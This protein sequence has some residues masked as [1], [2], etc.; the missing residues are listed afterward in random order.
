MICGLFI[1]NFDN[2]VRIVTERRI[3]SLH[4]ISR[5]I[6]RSLTQERVVQDALNGMQQSNPRDM[7]FA[8]FY[9]VENTDRDTWP[10]GRDGAMSDGIP[11]PSNMK[12][13]RHGSFAETRVQKR[14]PSIRSES[15]A[16]SGHQDTG[17]IFR[18]VGSYGIDIRSDTDDIP[19]DFLS[20]PDDVDCEVN[21]NHPINPITRLVRQVK[22]Q[23]SPL[24]LPDLAEIPFLASLSNG[25]PFNDSPGAAI[26]LP[27]RSSLEDRLHGVML[28]GLSTR[29]P[30]D[31]EYSNYVQLVKGLLA[32]GLATMKLHEE[33]LARARYMAALNRQKNEE[34]QSLLTHRTEELKTSEL[35]FRSAFAACPAAIWIG[36][37]EG[38]IW[39]MNQAYFKM[40]GLQT[41]ASLDDWIDR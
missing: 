9:I 6:N 39:D 15:V 2:T 40:S 22:S 33:D 24:F 12:S 31:G 26:V 38:G 35:K 13:K 27:I 25:N 19:L 37:P 32:T 18:L 23:D 41:N 10:G 34:L 17:A 4:E 30:W 8:L 11:D 14:L 16:S 20:V 36:G 28:L 7:H 5:C 29:A 21:A 3:R 1:P